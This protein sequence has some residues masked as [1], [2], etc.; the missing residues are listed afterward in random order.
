[1][2]L[3]LSVASVGCGGDNT[4]TGTTAKDMTLVKDMASVCGHPGDTGNSLGVGKYCTKITDC[5]GNSGAI[6]C[7][8]LGSDNA[9]F[10]TM[11]CKGADMGNECGENAACVCSG[12]QCGCFPDRCK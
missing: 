7:T 3:L 2:A 10:C 11:S 6:L 1:M 9:Y 5:S 4:G 8:V 12:G